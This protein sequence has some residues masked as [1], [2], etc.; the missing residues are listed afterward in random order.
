MAS[1]HHKNVP[2]VLLGIVAITAIVGLVLMFVS[3]GPT[4]NGVYGGAIKGDDTPHWSGGRG[5]SD[6][7]GNSYQGSND[8]ARIGS[9]QS[10]C[11]A[12]EIQVTQG[13]A[14]YYETRGCSTFPHPTLDQ[15]WCVDVADGCL[16]G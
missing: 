11:G 13:N 8:P 5:V 9:L 6:W 4:A 2:M 3:T 1:E 10:S 14:E 7:N 15:M 12:G 16:H